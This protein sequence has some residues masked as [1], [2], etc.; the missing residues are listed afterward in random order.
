[1]SNAAGSLAI[2]LLLFIPMLAAGGYLIL[3]LSKAVRNFVTRVFLRNRIMEDR[4]M[5]SDEDVA[6]ILQDGVVERVRWDDLEEVGILTTDEGPQCEDVYWLLLGADGK[7]GCV[8]PQSIKGMNELLDR[9]QKLPGFNNQ[10]VIEAMGS[11]SNAKFICWK[12]ATG[13]PR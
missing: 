4:L 12:R 5:I 9:L 6:R 7:S 11:T 2:A 13:S 8:V 1:M 10:S 3:G